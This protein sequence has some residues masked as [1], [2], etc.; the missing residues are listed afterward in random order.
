MERRSW[1]LAVLVAVLAI[2]AAA[3][4]T[5]TTSS[6]PSAAASATPAASAGGESAAPSEA[7]PSETPAPTPLPG[8]ASQAKPGDIVVRWYCCLGTG[9][10]PE[11]VE[12]E[13]KVAEDFNASHPG[14]HL[15]FE[16]YIYAAAADALSVQL[17]AGNAPDVVGPVGV[18]G[19]EFFHGQWLDLQPLIDKNSFDM[20]QYPKSTVDLYSAGGEGQVGIPYAIYPTVLFYQAGLFKEAGLAEPPHTFNSTYKMPDGQTVPWDYDTVQK[21][22]LRLTVD[23]NG[24]DATEAGFDPEKI[25]Q[26]GFEP[27]R[28]DLRQLG[29]N[30]KAGAFMAADGKTAQIARGL[31]RVLEAL[32]P[33]HLDGPHGGRLCTVPEHRLQPGRLPVLHRQGRH[34]HQLPVVDVRH[35]Q[36]R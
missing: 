25:V 20:S 19:A 12:V 34:E 7:A 29:A 24:K 22:A 21:I 11:Q 9:D 27:Q 2:L 26:W 4:G 6:S 33:E 32:L 13:Q 3:C 5:S 17:G 28:D 31:G 35:G 14:I 18:G 30:W 15:Q 1:R 8:N 16:G 23:E 10:Q 36:R